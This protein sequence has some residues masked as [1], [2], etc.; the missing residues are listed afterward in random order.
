MMT[1]T[2]VVDLERHNDGKDGL[3]GPFHD[4]VA[5]QAY[6]D[7]IPERLVR[8]YAVIRPINRPV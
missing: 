6:I 7:R 5:A 3:V 8:D 2:F 4:P 1:T